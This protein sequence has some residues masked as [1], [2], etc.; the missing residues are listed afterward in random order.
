MVGEPD[1]EYVAD[2]SLDRRAGDLVVE[3]PRSDRRSG[4]ERP[5]E[6]LG[7]ESDGDDPSTGVGLG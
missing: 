1:L 5:I 4:G 7:L 2:L 6:L 3:P